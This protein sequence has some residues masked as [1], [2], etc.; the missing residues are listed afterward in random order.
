MGAS[1]RLIGCLALWLVLASL[2]PGHARPRGTAATGR[3]ASRPT[4]PSF[5]GAALWGVRLG[6]FAAGKRAR[7]GSSRRRSIGS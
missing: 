3:K 6:D 5:P 1:R 2:G 7:A 4:S